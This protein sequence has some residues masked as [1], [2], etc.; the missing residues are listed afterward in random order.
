[1]CALDRATISEVADPVAIV[2]AVTGA[3]ALCLQGATYVRARPKLRV[4]FSAH[5]SLD[6]VA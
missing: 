1:L 6:V 5:A 4:G 3:L 2:G